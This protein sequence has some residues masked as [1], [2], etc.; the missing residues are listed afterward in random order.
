MESNA[1]L[2][3][4]IDQILE[5]TEKKVLSSISTSYSESVQ[6][7]DNSLPKLEQEYDR[8]ISEGKKEADKIQKQIVGSSDLE[9]RNKQLMALEKIV[10]DVFARALEQVA[11][12]DRS[13]SYADLI[14]TLLSESTEI[15]GTTQVV[16]STNSKDRDVV[17]SMLSEFSGAALSDDVIDCLGGVVV[18][19][20]DGTMKFDNTLDARIQRL[21]PLIR[22]EIATIFGVR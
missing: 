2:E 10:D 6:T 3:H 1:S 19:S 11:D 20:A 15:L 12:A 21:K 14:R 17:T 8:I 18:K 22:K 13:G 4:A 7:L 9:A 5:K 16:I